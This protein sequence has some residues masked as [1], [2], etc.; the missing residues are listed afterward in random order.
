LRRSQTIAL[1]GQELAANSRPTA[2]EIG[3]WIAFSACGS[4]LL[5][6]LTS[7][8]CQ[9]VAV[10]PFLWVAPLSLYLLTF[11]IAFD[12]ARWYLRSVAIPGVALAVALTVW[13][14]NRQFAWSEW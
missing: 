9:D 8:M 11:I 1:P 4:M 10:V 2:M 13:L 7:Q 12:H 6:S 5:M 3:L 14:L